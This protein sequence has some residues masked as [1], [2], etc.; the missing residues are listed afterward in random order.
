MGAAE[1]G[2]M[3][4]TVGKCVHT[5]YVYSLECCVSDIMED[6]ILINGYNK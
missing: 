5:A 3:S 2:E 4:Y 1:Q 6:V